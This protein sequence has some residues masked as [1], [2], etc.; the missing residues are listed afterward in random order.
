LD[1]YDINAGSDEDPEKIANQS[2]FKIKCESKENEVIPNKNSKAANFSKY[3]K[4]SM[5]E[6]LFKENVVNLLTR[7][8]RKNEKV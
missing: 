4:I 1:N 7:F 3:L 2:F 5:K 6:G 8:L